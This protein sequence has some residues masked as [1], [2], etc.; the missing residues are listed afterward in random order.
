MDAAAE[1]TPDKIVIYGIIVV[2]HLEVTKKC[3]SDNPTKL[4]MF[5]HIILYLVY[6]YH[7]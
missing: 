2:L 4:N 5:G 1:V 6:M 3:N 7:F